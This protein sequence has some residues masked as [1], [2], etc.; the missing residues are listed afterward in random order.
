MLNSTQHVQRLVVDHTNT[1]DINKSPFIEGH[2]VGQN[3]GR[4][5]SAQAA[6][7]LTPFRGAR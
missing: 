5:S 3:K 7:F 6:H 1:N 4:L 2:F